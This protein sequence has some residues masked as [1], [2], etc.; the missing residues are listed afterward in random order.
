MA[1]WWS[2]TLIIIN[3][4]IKLNNIQLPVAKCIDVASDS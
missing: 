2:M 1:D 3:N 4:N